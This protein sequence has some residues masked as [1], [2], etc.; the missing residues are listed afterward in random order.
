MVSRLAERIMELRERA[1][2][3]YMDE[4]A[5]TSQLA[6]THIKTEIQSIVAAIGILRA[7]APKRYDLQSEII[8][9]RAAMTGGT[10]ESQA[11][12]KVSS[13]DRVVREIQWATEQLVVALHLAFEAANKV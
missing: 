1:T 11:R 3:Y 12:L 6:A 9:L 4:N 13:D 10:F 8:V 7:R 2:A 5:G